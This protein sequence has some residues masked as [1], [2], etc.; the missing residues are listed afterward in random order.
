MK[1]DRKYY[2]LTVKRYPLYYP[3]NEAYLFEED[4]YAYSDIGA[5]NSFYRYH[6]NS[7]GGHLIVS[8]AEISKEEF[9]GH[10]YTHV[11]E[12]NKNG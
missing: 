8:T 7:Y 1:K 9:R 5:Q 3:I 11:L 6:A 10:H 12:E 4:V 2:R